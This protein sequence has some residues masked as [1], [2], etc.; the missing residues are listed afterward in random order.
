[1]R[2]TIKLYRW[3][4]VGALLLLGALTAA[5]LVLLSAGPQQGPFQYQ[6]F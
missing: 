2:R 1:M 4:L 5:L 6:I 3:Y